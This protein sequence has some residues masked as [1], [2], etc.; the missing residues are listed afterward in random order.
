MKPIEN[1]SFGFSD[2][3]NYKRRENKELLNHVFTKDHYL[4]EIGRESTS[5]LI[6]DKGTGK[7][8]YAV[9]YVNNAYSNTTASIRYVRET[10]Y[11]KF[12]TLKHE[13]HLALSDYSSVWKVI[14]LLSLY[15]SPS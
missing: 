15:K 2:A 9:Y 6:G 1:L 12:M 13:K 8:A 3:E 11:Q 14:I 4:E 5:F 7:T 10:E